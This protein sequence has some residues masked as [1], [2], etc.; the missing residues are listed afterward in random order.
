SLVTEQPL[1]PIFD[2]Q[3]RQGPGFARELEP[4]LLEMVGIEVAVAAGPHEHPRLKPALAREHMRQQSIGGDVEGNAEEDVGTALV[5]LQV[6]P[7]R[8][9]LCLE[10]TVT[11]R[12]RH[13]VDLARVPRGD[14]LPPRKRI[15]LDE[16]EEILD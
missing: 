3:L 6:E 4:R 12:E 15:A 2:H 7:P 10:Q 14:D 9:D 11:R 13:L 16:V 5:E 8:G 1:P